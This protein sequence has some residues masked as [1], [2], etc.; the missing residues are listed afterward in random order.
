[1]AGSGRFG[2]YGDLKR[3]EL[4]RRAQSFPPSTWQGL[5]YKGKRNASGSPRKM[6]EQ[7]RVIWKN[8]R[9]VTRIKRRR[10]RT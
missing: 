8:L 6:S 7:V 10:R 3:K 4:I 9:T 5:A 1:M 2:K